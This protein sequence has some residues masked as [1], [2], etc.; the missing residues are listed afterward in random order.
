MLIYCAVTGGLNNKLDLVKSYNFPK[1][2]VLLSFHYFKNIDNYLDLTNNI[3]IDSGAFTYQKTGVKDIKKYL[4]SYISFIKK[5]DANPKLNGFIEV[6]IDNKIGYA[7]VLSIREELEQHS[8]KILPVW[9][10]SLGIKEFKRMCN[11]YPYVCISGFANEDIKE[12][13]LIHFVNTAHKYNAKIHGLGL[14][15]KRVLNNVPFDSCDASSYF[16]VSRYG[17]YKNRKVKSEYITNNY[18][19]IVMVELT[20]HIKFQQEYYKKYKHIHKDK[21]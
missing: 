11:D 8:D 9:H 17:S 2:N 14:A 4:K 1:F 6:D 19:K 13:Q 21:M 16:K 20:N 5:Y 15:R 18:D 12:K 3:L 7:E 10:K